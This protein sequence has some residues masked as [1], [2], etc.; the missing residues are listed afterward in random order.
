MCLESGESARGPGALV[1]GRRG[2]RPPST[3]WCAP[4]PLPRPGRGAGPAPG[5]RAETLGSAG[6]G[7]W[8]VQPPGCTRRCA[9]LR[10]AR[11][12]QGSREG[13]D[14]RIRRRGRPRLSRPRGL[15]SSAPDLAGPEARPSSAPTAADAVRSPAP[16]V[17]ASSVG[18]RLLREPRPS[19]RIDVGLGPSAIHTRPQ[20]PPLSPPPPAP[21]QP[22]RPRDHG[23]PEPDEGKKEEKP[24]IARRWRVGT[25]RRRRGLPP[26]TSGTGAGVP[27]L[28][29]RTCRRPRRVPRSNPRH[30]RA[31]YPS[32]RLHLLGLFGKSGEGMGTEVRIRRLLRREPPDLK[33]RPGQAE[34]E[35]GAQRGAAVT[36]ANVPYPE[37]LGDPGP[38]RPSLRLL[39][40]PRGHTKQHHHLG[41]V[42]PPTRSGSTVKFR[43][44]TRRQGGPSEI[45]IK[46]HTH[47]TTPRPHL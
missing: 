22:P 41:E 36:T 17:P 46:A 34:R 1:T 18:L 11:S 4:A 15:G 3:A 35:T 47:G 13:L 37:T 45:E 28:P 23:K 20:A 9:A 5:W 16:T 14:Q 26:V 24:G 2:A 42:G 30:G 10:P 31:P 40:R 19:P 12:E 25:G 38:R 32:P 29:P 6:P 33:L 44:P 7:A 21:T 8:T 39:P 27:Q 43:G